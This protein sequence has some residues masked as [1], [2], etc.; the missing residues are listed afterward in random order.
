M[1][2]FC[3]IYIYIYRQSLW[4]LERD[5]T[6]IS[7]LKSSGDSRFSFW[8][9]EP[10][11]KEWNGKKLLIWLNS[12]LFYMSLSFETVNYV[13]FSEKSFFSFV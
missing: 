9:I 3:W 11:W 8:P 5:N 13:F 10:I 4:E 6:I 7:D 1:L 2:K 12:E